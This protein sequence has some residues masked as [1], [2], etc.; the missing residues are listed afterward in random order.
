MKKWLKK[1]RESETAFKIGVVLLIINPPIGWIGFAVGGYLSAKY[2]NPRY[3][4][5][6]TV[7]YA[8]TWGMAGAGVLL[9]GPRGV[10][11]ARNALRR[12]WRMIFRRKN[13][14]AGDDENSP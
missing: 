5:I 9:A 1:I 10:D 8:I 3:L 13:K 12:V 2:H 11:L 4:V 14:S 6:A 7:V